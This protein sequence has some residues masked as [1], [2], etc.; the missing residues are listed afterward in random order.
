MSPNFCRS[1]PELLVVCPR[2][3]APL[4]YSVRN[5]GPNLGEDVW[6]KVLDFF[7]TSGRPNKFPIK[8]LQLRDEDCCK[9]IKTKIFPMSGLIAFYARTFCTHGQDFLHPMSGLRTSYDFSAP[10]MTFL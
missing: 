3:F 5:F 10:C 4:I 8:N 1:V 6:G 9:S 7:L 2:T